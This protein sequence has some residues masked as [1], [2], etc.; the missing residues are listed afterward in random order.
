MR[1]NKSLLGL[2][3]G[4]L[5]TLSWP[6]TGSITPLIFLALVP[7]L[8]VVDLNNKEG[9]TW[10]GIFFPV[11]IAMLV[12][13]FGTTHWLFL[14]E[15][16]MATKIFSLVAPAVANAL[17]MVLPWLLYAYF[18]RYLGS[19]KAFLGLIFI[20]LGYEYFHQNW[21]LTWPWLLLGNVFSIRI[22]WI[23]WYEF[24]G[25]QGGTLWVLWVNIAV[26]SLLI[27]LPKNALSKIYAQ[28]GFWHVVLVITLPIIW[29]QVIKH[30]TEIKGEKKKV[31]A[32]QPN[33][34]PYTEKYNYG[35][36]QSH[37]DGFIQEIKKHPEMDLALL[38]E[39]ALQEPNRYGFDPNGKLI[40]N[41][42]W[43]NQFYRSQSISAIKRQVVNPLGT[44]VLS[45]VSS[46]KIVP[47]QYPDKSVLRDIS[48]DENLKM[49]AYNA[50]VYLDKKQLG[51]YH[52]SKLVPGVEITPYAWVF[53]NFKDLAMDL[54][55]TTGSLGAQDSREVFKTPS[56]IVAAPVICYESVFGEYCTEYVEKGANLICVLT[57][58]GWWQY[59]AGHKQHFA[60][61]RLRAIELRR[62]VIR[63]A[64]TGISCHINQLGEVVSTLGYDKKGALV[65][66]PHLNTELTVYANM[67]DYLGRNAL[68]ISALMLLMTFV[69][70][71]K[72]KSKL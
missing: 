13:N 50:A 36:Y 9:K 56:G 42:I 15:E 57:N 47:E 33:I 58:D 19:A 21:E 54:G 69:R 60:Y 32:I 24:V 55:G 8:F 26:Y 43:E 40:L 53:S 5:L 35:G 68:F 17:I 48:G 23:Q 44:A 62:D 71:V 29:S 46:M 4:I 31:L 66:E 27:K 63:S 49:I 3:S 12:W 11:F 7:L 28:R 52:K 2:L 51:V 14:V 72:S 39:T 41:G 64:N 37:L 59:S 65:C 10:G 22:N 61:A 30:N 38:P 45:G 6:Y 16:A 1:K 20:W 34:D 67:G 25:V 70:K 18:L